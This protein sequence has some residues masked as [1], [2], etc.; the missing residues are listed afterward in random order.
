[1]PAHH[2]AF[3]RLFMDLDAPESSENPYCVSE[4]QGLLSP[5]SA[6]GNGIHPTLH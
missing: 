6:S 2:P 5:D 4:N 1:M 3:L